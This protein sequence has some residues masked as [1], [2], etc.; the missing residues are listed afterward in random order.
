MGSVGFPRWCSGKESSCQ[1]RRDPG[2]ISR[3]G[4][5]PRRGNGNQLH[6]LPVH[7]LRSLVGLSPWDGRVG[8]SWTCMHMS[9]VVAAPRHQSTG[10][11]VVAHGLNCSVEC[12]ILPDQGSN[13]CHL[14]GRWILYHSATREASSRLTSTQ[15]GVA[16]SYYSL[17]SKTINLGNNMRHNQRRVLKV[18]KKKMNLFKTPRFEELYSSQPEES[19]PDP[20]FLEL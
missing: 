11:I 5:Y 2:L 1:C 6:I 18:S 12:G 7:E 17:I 20:S 19:D 13:P 15:D 9:P 14:H 10:S 8:H 16:L 3:S 4:R